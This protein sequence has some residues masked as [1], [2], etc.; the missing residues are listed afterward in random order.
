MRKRSSTGWAGS[1]DSLPT[2]KLPE[3]QHLRSVVAGDAAASAVMRGLHGL[4]KG[5]ADRRAEGKRSVHLTKVQGLAECPQYL[6]GS[7]TTPVR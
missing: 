5:Y 3:H 6:I 2:C 7:W 1:E 4:V